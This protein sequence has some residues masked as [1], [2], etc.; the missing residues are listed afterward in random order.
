MRLFA[1]RILPSRSTLE[2]SASASLP[3]RLL[4]M[5]EEDVRACSV[6]SKRWAKSSCSSLVKFWSRNTSTA[7]LSMPARIA[8]SDWR[9]CTWRRSI[10][11]TS[12]AKTG[13]SGVMVTVMGAPFV[14]NEGIILMEVRTTTNTDF[15]VRGI[16]CQAK[17]R[18]GW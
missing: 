3:N 17:V 6:P 7:Y 10:A 13:V 1:S 15:L 9:S 5:A 8:S 14:E 11:P 18:L 2:T 16:F 12:P 4:P